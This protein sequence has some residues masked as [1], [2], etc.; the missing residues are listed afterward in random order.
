MSSKLLI[1]GL[2]LQGGGVRIVFSFVAPIILIIC[3]KLHTLTCQL[4]STGLFLVL[5]LNMLLHVVL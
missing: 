5:P 1:L 3:L 4:F 2:A